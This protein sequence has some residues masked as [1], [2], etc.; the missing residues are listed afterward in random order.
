MALAKEAV[1]AAPLRPAAR[2]RVAEL[3]LNDYAGH[4]FQVQLAR[5]LARRDWRVTHAFCSSNATPHGDLTPGSDGAV[6]VPISA[7]NAFEK[8]GVA[9]RTMGEIRYGLRSAR[10]LLRDRAD[11]ALFAN[12]PVL[13]LLF[14]LAAAKLARSRTVVWVQDV[15]A[16]LAALVLADPGHPIVRVVD[17]LERGGSGGPTGR[18]RSPT[19]LR[20]RSCNAACPPIG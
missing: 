14:A 10:E 7:G 19:A 3:Y 2:K 5:E 20:R 4:P 18:S 11:V 1:A 9:R 6:I 13:S 15:Q 8:H 16:D 17:R 12:M